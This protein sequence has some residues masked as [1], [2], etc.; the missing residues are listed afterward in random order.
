[1]YPWSLIR[2]STVEHRRDRQRQ[3]PQVAA[4]RQVLDVLALDGE[5]F[6]ERQ[7]AA[8][9]HLHRPREPRLHHQPEAVLRLVAP[10]ELDLL[11]P[12]SDEAHVAREH[13]Q[14]LWQLVETRAPQEA[15]EPRHARVARELEGGLV[16]RVEPHE[17]RQHGLRVRTHRAELEDP[18]L[19]AAEPHP[20]L[21]VEDGT[22]PAETD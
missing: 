15:A 18:E 17:G 14:E 20:R 7:P 13:V 9:E 6:L 21:H 11:R 12:R 8:A 5:P 16:E 10:D 4:E 1:M 2:A 3:D 19:A 22:G